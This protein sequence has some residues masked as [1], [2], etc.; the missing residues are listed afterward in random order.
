M[1]ISW[2]WWPPHLSAYS[3]GPCEEGAV[4]QPPPPGL[5][6]RRISGEAVAP[7]LPARREA[8]WHCP[9]LTYAKR[10]VG[11]GCPPLASQQGG[12]QG[13]AAHPW[14]AS[15]AGGRELLPTPGLP[16]R[17][18]G[19]WPC[20]GPCQSGHRSCLCG[21]GIRFLPFL[22]CSSTSTVN[23]ELGNHALVILGLKLGQFRNLGG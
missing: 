22:T 3:P 21:R 10:E 4:G 2:P 13:V 5:P 14:P 23:T 20:M 19:R 1:I 16:T 8:G 15:K 17:Q 18:G 7:S 9:P 11:S 6:T 12:R